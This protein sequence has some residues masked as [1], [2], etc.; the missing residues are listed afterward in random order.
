MD[1]FV[2]VVLAFLLAFITA[3][4]AKG[5]GHSFVEW[6]IFG[7]L[8]FIVALPY[9]LLLKPAAGF[10]ETEQRAAG[11]KKCPDCAEMIRGEA[12]KCRYCGKVFDEAQPA[13]PIAATVT[14]PA[15]ASETG[16]SKGAKA[17]ALLAFLLLL[18][19]LFASQ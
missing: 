2:W 19:G 5:K 3:A 10:V 9:A 7:F 4:I 14:A 18:Y 11:M 13:A 16:V 17:I 12:L 8:L 6:W 15:R 1:L